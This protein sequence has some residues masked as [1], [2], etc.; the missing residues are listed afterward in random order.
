MTIGNRAAPSV[1]PNLAAL[2][3]ALSSCFAPPMVLVPVGLKVMPSFAAAG[4]HS[5]WLAEGPDGAEISATVALPPPILAGLQRI[6]INQMEIGQT[7]ITKYN[8]E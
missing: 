7:L 8:H 2:A 6:E 5:F 3:I 1:N 4:S